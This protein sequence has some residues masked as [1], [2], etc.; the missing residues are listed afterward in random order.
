LTP[1]Y[2]AHVRATLPLLAASGHDFTRDFYATLFRLDPASRDLFSGD[3]EAQGEKLMAM[4]VAIIEGLD[5][6]EGLLAVYAD[7]GHRHA[8]YGVTE[9]HYDAVGMALLNSL[10]ASLGDRFSA[11][12]EEA[13]ASVYGEIAEA[14]IAAGHGHGSAGTLLDRP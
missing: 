6:P 11:D 3:M 13:W 8:G 4:L 10:R 1:D 12:V 14:M 5:D 7:M 9:D 2:I